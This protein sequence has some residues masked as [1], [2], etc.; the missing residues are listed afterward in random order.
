MLRR[1][2]A[3]LVAAAMLAAAFGLA[4]KPQAT[5]LVIKAGLLHTM[6]GPAIRNGV[7]VVEGGKIL[8]VGRQGDVA[9][10]VGYRVIEAAVVTPGLIDARATVG[11]SGILNFPRSDQDMREGSGPIQPELRALDAYNPLDKLVGYLRSLGITTVNTGHAPGSLMSGQTFIAKTI[12]NTADEAAIVPE[13]MVSA[14][15]DPS[16][17]Q[18]KGAPGTRAKQ[19]S[20]LRQELMKAQSAPE[21]GARDLR[22]EMLLRVLR[23]EIPIL[24]FADRA[25]DIATAL[26]LQKEFNL[27]MI[28]E[29]AA[30]GYLL[31]DQIKAAGVPVIV[32]PTMRRTGGE[33]ENLTWENAARLRRAGVTIA[34]QSGYEGY[35]PKTR[36]VLFEAALAAANGLGPEDALRTI[37]IDAAKILGI[38]RRVGSLEVGKDADLALYDGDPF[39]WTSHCLGTIINGNVVSDTRR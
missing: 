2:K 25:Q 39:E 18:G 16:A 23:R 38:D 10:P 24:V 14:T 26:R 8:A 27:R 21:G 20:T 33:T 19:V 17:S 35:V 32:H 36:V 5:G 34:L 11:L 28:L 22:R 29:S 7:V 37:T 15:L 4:A 31:A 12:G 30:E 1:L 3:T 9:I 6:T 13:A